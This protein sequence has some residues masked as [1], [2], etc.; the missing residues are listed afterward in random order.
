MSNKTGK[1]YHAL[2]KK[3]AEL[4]QQGFTHRAIAEAIGKQPEQIKA[5]ILLGE[6]LKQVEA[7]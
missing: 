7:R 2:S 3:A 1:R 5:M 6:R 4:A